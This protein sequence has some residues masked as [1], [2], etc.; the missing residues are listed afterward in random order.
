MD[1]TGGVSS[2]Q[3]VLYDELATRIR[4]GIYRSQSRDVFTL[5]QAA[6]IQGVGAPL[7]AVVAGSPVAVLSEGRKF[8]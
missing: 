3:L 6:C 4:D 5:Y 7:L 8:R 2:V 1:R